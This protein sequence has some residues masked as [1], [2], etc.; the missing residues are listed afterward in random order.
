VV[1]LTLASFQGING[2]VQFI[3][4]HLNFIKKRL[5]RFIANTG[6]LYVLSEPP[7]SN[8][9]AHLHTL[10]ETYSAV[11]IFWPGAPGTCQ[12]RATCESVGLTG[13]ELCP[14]NKT[15]ARP[16][17]VIGGHKVLET[18]TATSRSRHVA[19]VFRA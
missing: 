16:W 9:I 6:L 19:T 11:V 15:A 4:A 12:S 14:E 10:L 13:D 8:R 5:K 18:C 17:G 3:L 2:D 1:S 7:L